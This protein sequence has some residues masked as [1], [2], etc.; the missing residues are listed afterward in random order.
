MHINDNTK[1]PKNNTDKLYKVHPFLQM[2]NDQFY[3]VYHGTLELAA[4]ESII[5]FKGRS[6][7]EEYIPMKPV[8][9]RYV[10][11]CLAVQC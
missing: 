11:W 9:R 1:I 6:N 4:D 10:I 8:K 3:A 7:L 2:L 5:V